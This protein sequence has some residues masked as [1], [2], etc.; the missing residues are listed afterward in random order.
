[1]NDEQE[2]ASQIRYYCL[3]FYG[4]WKVCYSGSWITRLCV[5]E[6]L[7]LKGKRIS[8][9][10]APEPST[11]LWENYGYRRYDEPRKPTTRH[12]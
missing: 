10:E 2:P 6:K 5:K 1:M 7:K 12:Q 9:E 4:N 3:L 11:I 8:V